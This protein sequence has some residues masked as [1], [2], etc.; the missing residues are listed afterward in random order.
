MTLSEFNNEFDLL[1]NN[2][3]SNQAPGLDSYEKSVFLTMA[4]EEVIKSYFSRAL[5][6]TQEGFDDSPQRQIDFSMLIEVKSPSISQGSGTVNLQDSGVVQ[7]ALPSDVMMILN[8]VLTVRRGTGGTGVRLQVIPITYSNYSRLMSKAYKRPMKSQAW[9]LQVSGTGNA[10]ADL[11]A[12]YGDY[13]TGYTIR[14]VKRPYPIIIE[15]LE[16]S[17]ID[18]YVGGV[19]SGSTYVPLTVG[20]STG[21]PCLLDPIIHRDILQRAVELAKAAYTEGLQGQLILGQTSA[22]NIGVVASNK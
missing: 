7:V 18:G 4:Q 17:T 22:T 12:S 15:P 1:Y 16:N 8:E 11:I 10:K 19:Q 5:N 9:R 21:M 6:K 13:P 14:Y 3:M 2:I 20:A